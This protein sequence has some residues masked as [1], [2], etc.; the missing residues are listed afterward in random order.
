MTEAL[1]LQITKKNPRRPPLKLGSK[2]IK[3]TGDGI[4]KKALGVGGI[5][6]QIFYLVNY[7]TPSFFPFVILKAKLLTVKQLQE[8]KKEKYIIAYHT[9]CRAVI[10]SHGCR[11]QKELLI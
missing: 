1:P 9:L 11:M 8:M 4:L 5:N 6:S 7:W 10:P 2:G 3:T